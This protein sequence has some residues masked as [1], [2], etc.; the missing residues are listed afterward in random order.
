MNKKVWTAVTV[1]LAAMLVLASCGK[2]PD[3]E[4][5]PDGMKKYGFKKYTV[6]NSSGKPGQV[7]AE[8]YEN[9]GTE[10]TQKIYDDNGNVTMLNKWYYD[11][12]GE[13]L[14]KEVKW[15]RNR[16][17]ESK[18]YDM[19]GRCTL[20]QEKYEEGAG[21]VSVQD[22]LVLPFEYFKLKQLGGFELLI[23]P[24]SESPA[25]AANPTGEQVPIFAVSQD[26]SELR[27]E[28][29]YRGDTSEYTSICTT[30]GTGEIVG[31]LKFGESNEVL[32][33][34]IETARYLYTAN[35]D[36]QT[37][38]TEWSVSRV[39]GGN[40]T[41]LTYGDY[42]YDAEGTCIRRTV[43]NREFLDGT[44]YEFVL[45]PDSDG[46][47]YSI[48]QCESEQVKKFVNRSGYTL[49]AKTGIT[50]YISEQYSYGETGEPYLLI[51]DTTEYYAS[52]N[53]A[54]TVNEYR[55]SENG[56][57][58][59]IERELFDSEEYKTKS[60]KST[61]GDSGTGVMIVTKKPGV[62]VPVREYR[63]ST[64]LK[65][66]EKREYIA[67]S[68]CL[69]DIYDYSKENWVEYSGIEIYEGKEYE[70][71]IAEF[72]EEGHLRKR[73]FRQTY[74]T[75]D[76]SEEAYAYTEEYDERGRIIRMTE[77]P[78]AGGSIT[79]WEYWEK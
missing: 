8:E 45:E 18:E 1:L 46:T 79:T 70:E 41:K 25:D 60:Y 16:P 37:R 19:L 62:A 10:R 43:H 28:Y 74:Y 58:E 6:S 42:E 71:C 30:T 29:V 27:T 64:E 35:Y 13:H 22:R 53:L 20:L 11:D 50:A 48:Y 49:N 9:L 23:L 65:E 33:G 59:V 5:T 32:Y 75:E 14:L 15:D 67:L 73:S 61:G 77:T 54:R 21:T 51:R 2:E 55:L 57:W 78:S 39:S 36:E 4:D 17:T 68:A 7:L 24:V 52:G 66:G 44:W 3:R 34:R 76:D 31:S 26:I 47:W 38:R 72:D 12:T 63:F 56:E 69:C 40:E